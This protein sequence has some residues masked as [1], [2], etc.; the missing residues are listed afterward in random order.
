MKINIVQI[1]TMLNKDAKLN[2]LSCQVFFKSFSLTFVHLQQHTVFYV[3]L[4]P[5]IEYT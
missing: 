2:D 4:L 3:I 1:V 5:L